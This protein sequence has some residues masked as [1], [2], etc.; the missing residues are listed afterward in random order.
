MYFLIDCNNFYASCERVFNP[1]LARTPIVVLSNNDG[2]V[3]ARSNEAKALGIPMGAPV[4]ECRSLIE[5]NNVQVFSSN[6]TLYGDMSARV[7]NVIAQFLPEEDFEVYSIDECFLRFPPAM[8][9]ERLTMLAREIRQTVKQYT[10][11]P[12]SIGIAPTKTLA[13]IANRVAKKDASCAGVFAITDDETRDR[14]LATI[15]VADVW[16]IGSQLSAKFRAHGIMTALDF[17]NAPTAW[18]RK[19]ATVT[20]ARTQSELQGVSCIPLDT[21]TEPRKTI[22]HSRTFGARVH[23]REALEEV[24]SVFASRAAER[25]RH[26]HSVCS[27][28]T[29]GLRTVRYSDH[30][31]FSNSG[32]ITILPSHSTID[33]CRAAGAVLHSIFREGFTYKKAMVMLLDIVP[34]THVPLNAFAVNDERHETIM[35][36]MDKLNRRFGRETISLAS[37]G[38]NAKPQAWRMQQHKL[39][40][41]YTTQWKHLAAVHSVMQN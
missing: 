3:V 24:I 1:R 26:Q 16:G 22:C 15:D 5:N 11:I 28:I 33:I 17:K 25:L 10:G 38:S 29:V 2:C 34:E 35:L 40:P 21:V 30:Q 36:A 8:P 4:F 6:Y 37:S 18:I 9:A 20:G 12:V 27:A 13:K 19:A 14:T 32:T 39:S 31:Y 7:M 41:H 23:E